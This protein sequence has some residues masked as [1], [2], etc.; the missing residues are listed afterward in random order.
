MLQNAHIV[1]ADDEKN[2]RR[3]LEIIL[4]KLGYQVTTAVDGLEA[5]EIIRNTSVDLLITDLRMPKMDGLA[6]LA[7]LRQENIDIPVIVVT[8]YGTVEN[9]VAAMKQGAF[10]FIVRPLD[11]EQ[12]QMVVNHALENCRLKQEN[13]FLRDQLNNHGLDEFI[14]QSQVMH[15]IYDLIKQVAPSKTS[16][17]ISGE[18]GTGK[19]LVASVIHRYSERSGLFVPVNCA[20]IPE[21]MLESELFGYVRGAFTG[22]DKDRMGKFELAHQG[23]LFLDEITEMR[24]E[25]QAKLLRVL[26]ENT[27]ERLGSNRS[28]EIDTRIITATNRNPRLAVKEGSLREDIFYRLNVFNISLPSL[29]DRGEDILLLAN[30]FIDKYRKHLGY[31]DLQLSTAACEILTSY[32]WPGN[33]RELQNIMERAVVLSRGVKIDEEH[34]PH[35]L[36]YADDPPEMQFQSIDNDLERSVANLE[37]SM[38]NNALKQAKGSKSKAARSLN[39]SERTLWYKFKKYQIDSTQDLKS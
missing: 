10:D 28:F 25:L 26:Q 5:F 24:P 8:A 31:P 30:T 6:L 36:I 13:I 39:I 11:I 2:G 17:F 27:I 9:A 29:R 35:E 12:V 38:I 18:T 1:I 16:V 21:N 20:A 7:A 3:M 37:I 22:A 14:G 4:N 32:N 19:E 34:L 23:T 15:D 33:V